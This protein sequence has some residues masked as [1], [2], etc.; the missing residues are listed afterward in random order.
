MEE[1]MDRDQRQEER[2]MKKDEKPAKYRNNTEKSL[3]TVMD[4]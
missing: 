3:T 2:R 4:F 1:W